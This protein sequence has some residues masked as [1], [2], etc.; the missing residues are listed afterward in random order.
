[1]NVEALVG[2]DNID[3]GK[4]PPLQ[5]LFCDGVASWPKLFNSIAQKLIN[6]YNLLIKR[7]SELST[8][9]N[10]LDYV[11]KFDLF[12]PFSNDFN[13]AKEKCQFRY[14]LLHKKLE[15]CNSTL[16]AN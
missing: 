14:K 2:N 5:G 1:M 10:C 7:Y 16:F 8:Y 13:S 3:F 4:N 12:Q 9:T 6:K 15:Y 11:I